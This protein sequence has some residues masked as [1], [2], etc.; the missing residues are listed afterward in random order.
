MRLNTELPPA[1]ASAYRWEFGDGTGSGDPNPVKTYATPGI[2]T[3]GLSVAFGT[4]SYTAARTN[5]IAVAGPTAPPTLRIRANS[6]G[7]FEISIKGVEGIYYALQASS[8][9][10]QWVA[11]T[12]FVQ[13]AS[14]QMWIEQ[15]P[16]PTQQF[17]RAVSLP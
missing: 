6:G 13:P 14:E 9:L 1:P 2:Y 10:H 16:Q 12:N 5:Y 11:V 4:A 15:S 8:D 17:Y 3:V 7:A